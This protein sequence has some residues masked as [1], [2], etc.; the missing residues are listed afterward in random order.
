MASVHLRPQIPGRTPA[1]SLCHNVLEPRASPAACLGPR[2]EA[3]TKRTFDNQMK[4]VGKKTGHAGIHAPASAHSA[5]RPGC[6]DSSSVAHSGKQKPLQT[7]RTSST[8]IV[9]NWQAGEMWM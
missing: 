5:Q 3:A 6:P 2:K 7:K 9:A 8:A 4:N 1:S